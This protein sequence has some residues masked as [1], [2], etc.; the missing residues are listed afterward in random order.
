MI[1]EVGI[2]AGSFDLILGEVAGQLVDDGA[3][4]L[5]V[6]QLLGADVRQQGLQLRVGH[7]V[8]LAQI[9][10]GGAQLTVRAAVLADDDRRQLGVGGRDL[11]RVLQFLLIDKH[12]SFPPSSQGQGSFSQAKPSSGVGTVI[13]RG[14]YSF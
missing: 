3:H 1:H 2:K 12:Q 8:A 13:C 14:P 5:E 10:Q 11:H 6:S 4:H 7:G 9:A